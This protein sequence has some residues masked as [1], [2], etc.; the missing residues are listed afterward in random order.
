MKITGALNISKKAGPTSHDV[1]DAVRKVV[2]PKTKVGHAGTLDPMAEGVLPICIGEATKL[3]PYFLEC[4]KT[5]KAVL[6]FGRVTD[7]QDVTGETISEADPGAISLDEAQNLLESLKGK[8]EQIPPMF[9]AIRVGGARLHELARAG[10]E[11][12]REGRMVEIHEIQACWIEGPRVSFEVTCSRGTYIRTLCHDVGALQGS[13]GCMEKLVR[14]ALGPFRLEDSISVDEVGNLASKG[15]LHE[16]LIHPA[17]A[18]SHMP[19]L[20]VRPEAEK[21]LRNGVA[22]TKNDLL[23]DG[24]TTPLGDRACLLSGEGKLLAVCRVTPGAG[25]SENEV[26]YRPERVFAR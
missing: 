11:V 3:F 23:F 14:T 13:G 10:V 12:E 21:R 20:R 6:L 16:A 22:L 8:H 4:R 7:S 9:S 26:M 1:V 24:A 15:R 25:G 2:S 19:A 17:D 18:L 5:Y